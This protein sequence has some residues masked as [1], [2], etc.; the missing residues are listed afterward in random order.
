MRIFSRKKAVS[1]AAEK[2]PKKSYFRRRFNAVDIGV[3]T[4]KDFAAEAK[5]NFSAA[6]APSKSDLLFLWSG[7][8]GDGKTEFLDSLTDEEIKFGSDRMRF[9]CLV[10]VICGALILFGGWIGFFQ[11]VIGYT[12]FFVGFIATAFFAILTYH[13]SVQLNNRRIMGLRE[14]IFG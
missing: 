1:E 6:K 3:G 5:E 11:G 9:T 7:P 12:S 2:A 8:A 14:T 4:S 10:S 13:Q